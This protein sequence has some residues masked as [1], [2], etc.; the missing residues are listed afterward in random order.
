[1]LHRAPQAGR[2]GATRQ[3]GD[4]HLMADLLGTR[5]VY[6]F[7]SADVA[8]G[9]QGAPL[10]AV[11]HAALCCETLGSGWRR[12]PC[13]IWAASPMS[14]G[15]TAKDLVIAFDTGPANA[16]INDFVK[17]H[18]AWARWTATAL[19]ALSGTGRRGPA[20]KAS[21]PTPI[22]TAAPIPSRWIASTSPPPWPTGSTLENGAA[23]LTAFTHC[24]RRQG[25]GPPA[26]KRPEKTDRLR[27]RPAQSGRS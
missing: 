8:A 21:R 22:M 1:V 15:G 19:L 18:G 13:S 10:S 9:G 20:R 11:Y 16:P 27:R 25:A 5:V 7:R 24:G 3:L 4:G 14:P 2:I 6:D 12:R 23:T 17:S 26:A